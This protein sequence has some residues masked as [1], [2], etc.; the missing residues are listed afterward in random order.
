MAENLRCYRCGD[1]LAALTLPISRQDQC[2]SCSNYL[3]VCRMCLYF[4]ADVPRQCLED[5]AE[6]V[7]EKDKLNFCEWYKPTPTAFDPARNS[8]ENK[9]RSELKALF[10]DAGDSEPDDDA[11][12]SAAEDLFH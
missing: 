6:D 2:P 1:S 12:T 7:V 9:A 10:G 11:R 8:H 3:R 4:D 5:D